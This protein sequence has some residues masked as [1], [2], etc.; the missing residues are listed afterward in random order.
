MT[1][2][3]LP[4]LKSF[5]SFTAIYENLVPEN[6]QCRNRL[7]SHKVKNARQSQT[8]NQ[9]RTKN[10]AMKTALN[11]HVLNNGGSGAL[12]VSEICKEKMVCQQKLSTELA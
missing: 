5:V 8:K 3:W 2:G 7:S 12:V 6:S 10:S 4:V 1:K 9:S 11:N